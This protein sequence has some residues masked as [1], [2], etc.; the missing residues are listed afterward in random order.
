MSLTTQIKLEPKGC[1]YDGSGSKRLLTFGLLTSYFF[2]W[3]FALVNVGNASLPNLVGNDSV[4][5]SWVANWIPRSF[6]EEMGSR[7]GDGI[8]QTKSKSGRKYRIYCKDSERNKYSWSTH[9]Q[10]DSLH[11]GTEWIVHSTSSLILSGREG[12]WIVL[13]CYCFEWL[14]NRGW[15]ETILTFSGS[16]IYP[17][18][19][20]HSQVSEVIKMTNE[21]KEEL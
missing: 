17:R 19:N 12:W 7:I 10:T 13:S 6:Y 21:A 20:L 5:N 9:Y 15:Y 4:E 16:S 3:L 14:F 2:W 8:Y 1:I 18:K 11:T